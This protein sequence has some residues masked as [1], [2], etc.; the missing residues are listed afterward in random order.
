MH[1]DRQTKLPLDTE[2]GLLAMQFRGAKDEATRAEVAAA[3]DRVV[4]QLIESGEWEEMPS[5]E[6]MLPDERMPEA[7]FTFW[8]IPS[9]H[10]GQRLRRGKPTLLVEG[11]DDEAIVRAL[12]PPDLVEVSNLGPAYGKATL[13][14]AAR[15]Y[16][17]E[18]HAPTAILLDTETLVKADIAAM[19]RTAKSRLR[20]VAGDTPF[21]VFCC[22]PEIEAIFFTGGVELRRIFPA[23]E[24]V[25]D[26]ELAKVE[27]KRSLETLFKS[28]KGPR[29]LIDFLAELTATEIE[30]LRSKDPIRLVISFIA[31][32]RGPGHSGTRRSR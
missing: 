30:H 17:S 22:V 18:H 21:D 4:A 25:F 9:P 15:A 19:V 24:R 5:F 8:S 2:L 1:R 14:W 12:L 11:M 27:P 3:Y 32:N 16:I 20:E 28:G 10:A 13:V 26:Q 31:N 7:F 23:W 6:D 29:K